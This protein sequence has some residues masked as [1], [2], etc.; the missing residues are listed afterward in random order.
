MARVHEALR[1]HESSSDPLPVIARHWAKHHPVLC[2][3]EFFV[4]DIADAM[5]LGGLLE[6]LFERGVTLVATSNVEPRD[7]YRDG[8]QRSR[9]LPAIAAIERHTDV[10]HVGGDTDHRLRLLERSEIYHHPLD[11]AAERLL[12]EAWSRM[13]KDSEMEPWLTVR[14]RQLEARRRGG[15]MIWFDFATLC[16][17]PTGP[18]DYIEIARAFDTVFLSGIEIM[19]EEDSDA[20]RRFVHLVDELYDRNVKLLATAAA[21]IDGLYTGRRLAFEFERTRS[22][23]TEMQTHAYLAQAHLP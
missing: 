7:L 14:G 23:L 20:A 4:S 16:Q 6:A 12:Q 11:E 15:G 10:L 18:T 9:F 2:F 19:A 21:P 13:A 5:L 8:L 22:R 17:G 1:E 3:D